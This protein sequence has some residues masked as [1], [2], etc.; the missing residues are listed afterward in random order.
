MSL[1]LPHSYGAGNAIWDLG[2]ARQK[3]K[4]TS[5][6]EWYRV[7]NGRVLSLCLMACLGY[8]PWNKM[9]VQINVLYVS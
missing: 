2:I 5:I 3:K 9:T 8:H 1:A 7:K 6:Q 4:K